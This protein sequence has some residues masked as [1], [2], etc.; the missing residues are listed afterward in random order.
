[1]KQGKIT[2]DGSRVSIESGPNG[3]ILLTRCQLA[4]LFGVYYRTITANIKAIIK[5][6]RPNFEGTLVQV[7][8]TALPEHYDMEM[9]VALAFR[10]D[11][12]ATELIRRY[13]VGRVAAGINNPAP[14]IFL[15]F[16][17]KSRIH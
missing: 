2:I 9:V 11:T 8:N 16:G 12:L 1:M 14:T 17:M 13:V 7:G 3:Q 4:D 5:F 6:G 15:S 10:L